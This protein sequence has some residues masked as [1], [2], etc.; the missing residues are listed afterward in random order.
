M[1][2]PELG[3]A[4]IELRID[5]LR[6]GGGHAVEA[7]NGGGEIDRAARESAVLETINAVEGIGRLNGGGGL[8]RDLVFHKTRRAQIGPYLAGFVGR[9][10]RYRKCLRMMPL[11]LPAAIDGIAR[12]TRCA[13]G[14]SPGRAP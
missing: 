8:A 7:Q 3:C 2:E 6:G 9:R 14:S 13:L 1:I 4:V 10:V 12:K 11:P 5:G